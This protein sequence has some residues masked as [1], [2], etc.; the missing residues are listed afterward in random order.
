MRNA[1]CLLFQIALIMK[2]YVFK[3]PLSRTSQLHKVNHIK[4]PKLKYHTHFQKKKKTQNKTNKKP[5]VTALFK[6]T[7]INEEI[8]LNAQFCWH[9][10]SRCIIFLMFICKQRNKLPIQ[11][12][13]HLC[14]LFF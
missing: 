6:F 5:P 2:F 4:F 12:P 13:L 1:C 8:T 14:L 11:A 9:S 3:Q 7:S 10:Y